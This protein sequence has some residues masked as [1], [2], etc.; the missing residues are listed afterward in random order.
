MFR[1][2]WLNGVGVGRLSLE[3]RTT[4]HGHSVNV[5]MIDPYNQVLFWLDEMGV[6]GG[7]LFVAFTFFIWK[8]IRGSASPLARGVAATWSSVLLAG[9]FNTLFG[10]SGFSCG[11]MLVGSLLGI[12]MRLGSGEAE[13]RRA[14]SV[15]D[16]VSEPALEPVA[17]GRR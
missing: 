5:A 7:A 4:V 12:T 10:G 1:H 13:V 14:I 11:N 2:H 9:L 6:F 16:Q 15:P 17:P 8:A 3:V